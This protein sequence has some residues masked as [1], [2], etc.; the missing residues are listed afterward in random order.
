MDEKPRLD[1]RLIGLLSATKAFQDADR[2][3]VREYLPV[4]E[5][6]RDH[7]SGILDRAEDKR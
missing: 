1:Q 3:A 4:L 5:E 7:L 6:V 2:N